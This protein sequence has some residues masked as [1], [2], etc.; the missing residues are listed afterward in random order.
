MNTGSLR[1]SPSSSTKGL[2]MPAPPG[3]ETMPIAAGR[4]MITA[5][6]DEKTSLKASTS[7]P[8]MSYCF[9]SAL[10]TPICR[11]TAMVFMVG[12]EVTMPVKFSATTFGD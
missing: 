5:L 7:R 9:I 11:M 10:R 1:L 12:G 2:E 4:I 8:R 3:T 6:A